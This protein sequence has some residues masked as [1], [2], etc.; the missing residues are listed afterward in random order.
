LTALDCDR[1]WVVRIARHPAL[2]VLQG[3]M[4]PLLFRISLPASIRSFART[5]CP[6]R[7]SPRLCRRSLPCTAGRLG[8]A[9]RRSWG[10]SQLSPRRANHRPSCPVNTPS[11]VTDRSPY[12]VIQARVPKR[13]RNT[14]QMAASFPKPMA[15]GASSLSRAF[16]ARPMRPTV[17]KWTPK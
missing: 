10:S 14:P 9:T 8:V 13:S 4:L 7:L 6:H 1:E 11:E 15:T 16:A 2:Q 12:G 3:P 5:S 17:V